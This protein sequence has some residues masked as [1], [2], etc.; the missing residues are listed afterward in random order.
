MAIDAVETDKGLMAVCIRGISG[1]RAGV[2]MVNRSVSI[3]IHGPSPVMLELTTTPVL[4]HT[5]EIHPMVPVGAESKIILLWSDGP[6][7]TRP[8][9]WERILRDDP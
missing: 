6:P 3:P 2:L 1:N 8:T 5:V 4:M 9:V 7:T